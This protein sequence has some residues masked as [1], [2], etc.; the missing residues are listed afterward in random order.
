MNKR[1]M[2]LVALLVVALVAPASVIQAQS[3]TQQAWMS[4]IT[5]Y[6]PSDTGGELTISFYSEGSATPITLDPIILN[7]HAAGSLYVGGVTELGTEFGGTAVLE[8]TVYVIATAVQFAVSPETDNY[9]RLLYS[10]FI[11]SEAASPFYV[12][13]VL[14]AKYGTT[15]LIAIQNTASFEVTANVKF[16]AVGSTTPTVDKNYDIPTQSNVILPCNDAS[17]VGL[18]AGFNGSA[19]IEAHEKGNPAVEGQVVASVQETKDNGRGAYAFEGLAAGANTIYMATML[20]DIWGGNNSYYAIQNSSLT[21]TAQVTIDFYDTSGNKIAELPSTS[22]NPGNKMSVNPCT[23]TDYGAASNVPAGTSGSAVI[24]STGAPVMAIG[25]VSAPDGTATAFVGQ[26]AGNEKIAAPYIRW[27]ADPAAG[28]RAYVAVMNVGASD[29]AN[30]VARYYDGNG[31]EVG[32]ETLASAGDP[33]PQFI[34]R[35]TNPESAGALDGDGNFGVSPYGGA[36]ELESDQ[37]VVVVVRIARNVSL[38]S[39]T[40]FAEDYN[41]VSIP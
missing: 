18:S 21:D 17:K 34:K 19:V 23:I 16:Y 2:L 27:A 1:Y 40:R 4:S 13:T 24:S 20:C 26:A 33:L 11:P 39:T 36:V 41:G 3:A 31:T 14:N 25:K 29:A 7:P 9:G 22:L 30:I 37:P 32:S 35:N 28:W 12:P 8:S 5:Y 15:S 38:G 10:G 6:T